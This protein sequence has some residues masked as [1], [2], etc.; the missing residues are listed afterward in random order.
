MFWRLPLGQGL[1]NDAQV[2]DAGKLVC[3]I[4]SL[5]V[6]TCWILVYKRLQPSQK[7]T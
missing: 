7:R 6:D 3:L 5:K 2:S 1:D 4:G